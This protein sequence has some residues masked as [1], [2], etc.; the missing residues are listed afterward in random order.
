MNPEPKISVIIPA[1]NCEK[2][3]Q[4][5]LNS[6]LAQSH[7]N[8][9]VLIADDGSIDR[10]KK[11][12]DG[13]SD[14]RIKRFHNTENIGNVRTRNKLFAEATGSY[15]C[16]QDADDWSDSERLKK[17]LNLIQENNLDGCLCGIKKI[18]DDKEV[19][20]A[21]TH[22]FMPATIM[23][24]SDVYKSIG[25]IPE[26]L[27]RIVA[28]DNYWISLI[29]EKFNIG[30][31]DEALYYHRSNPNSLTNSFSL[32]ILTAVPLIA[33]LKRQRK[34]TGTDWVEQGNH[35]QIQQFKSNLIQDKNWLQGA[36]LIKSLN[37]S[38]SDKVLSK[39]VFKKAI[40]VNKYRVL[41]LRMFWIGIK[42]GLFFGA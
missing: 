38:K 14:E 25:G 33:E 23:I 11:L 31:L 9:E 41:F 32:E 7:Q 19:P 28:E 20:H 34:T 22:Y 3:I 29:K 13:Y 30:K 40:K 2:Y 42:E 4:K 17:Q 10:T 36:L 15:Y 39:Q 37:L 12:I 27:E 24:K 18:R 1:F 35:E 26:L 21:S 8:I 5:C 16:I 6:I